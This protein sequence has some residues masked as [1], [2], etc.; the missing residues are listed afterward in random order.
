MGRIFDG[1]NLMSYFDE[2]DPL[3]RALAIQDSINPFRKICAWKKAV[4]FLGSLLA[5]LLH[6]DWVPKGSGDFLKK[7]LEHTMTK[8]VL[9][10]PND[11]AN[12]NHGGND[13]PRR[14]P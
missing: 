14:L 6:A 7:Q 11:P 10:D 1:L 8:P 12:M 3:E 13:A 4:V 2:N 9:P 5:S